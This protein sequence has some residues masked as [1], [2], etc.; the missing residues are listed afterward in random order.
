MR[1]TPEQVSQVMNMRFRQRMKYREIGERLDPPR[2]ANQV[3][4]LVKRVIDYETDR[5]NPVAQ[6]IIRS[7][8]GAH[9]PPAEVLADRD[10]RY[11]ASERRDT[12]AKLCGDPEVP[13]WNSNATIRKAGIGIASALALMFLSGH[14]AHAKQHP[15]RYFV[16]SYQR[17]AIHWHRYAHKHHRWSHH[18][19]PRHLYRSVHL[20]LPG[21]CRV[22][23]SMGGPCGCWAAH[24]LLDR[25]DHVW[26]GV[27]LWLADDWLKFP[28]TAPA[29]G[30]AVV[31]P[32]RHVAPVIAVHNDRTGKPVAV[33]VRVSWAVHRVSLA[34]LVVV[35]PPVRRPELV[36]WPSGALS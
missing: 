27:N 2:T 33:T 34:G 7:L 31:W 5:K 35:Q 14:A 4:N 23:A 32:H 17:H 28:R 36:R 30:T 24:V 25:L 6:E 3:A 26:R 13:R 8:G 20:H 10:A 19:R 1:I 16:P 29:P 9:R 18:L 12:T 22:A 21:P 15:Y 11:E